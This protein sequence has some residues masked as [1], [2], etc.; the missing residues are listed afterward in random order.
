[1]SFVNPLF[2]IGALAVAAPILLHLIKREHARKIEFPSLMFLRR[3]SRKS[4]RYQKL[5]HLLILLLR[6]LAFLL[7]VFAFMRPYREK[8]GAASVVGKINSAHV[9]LIDNSLSMGYQ[10]RWSRAKAAAAAIVRKADPDDRFA[11]LEFSDR[12]SALT[13]LTNDP[14]DAQGQI[15]NMKLSDGSTRYGQALRAAEKFALDAG[16]GKRV[17]HLISDFQKNGFLTDDQDFRLSAGIELRHVDMGA[18]SYSNLA[19]RDVHVSE[20]DQGAGNTITIKA[21]VADFGDQDRKNVRV[22]LLVDGR[23][24]TEKRVDIVKGGSQGIEF[25]L[26]ALLSGTHSAIIEVDDPYLAGDNRFY[27]T[28]ETRG[29]T[30]VLVVESGE[31]GRSSSFFLSKALNVDTLSPYK[32]TAVT[33]QSFV[34]SGGL[35]IWNN[36]AGGGA[37]QKKLQDFVKT[38]GGLALVLGDSVQAAEFNHSFGSWLPVR[39]EEPGASAGFSGRR[40]AENYVM[41]TDVRMD[42]PIFQPFSRPHSGSFSSARFF[43]HARIS[44]GSGAEILSRFDNGDPALVS[45]REEKGRV[46][47]FTSSADDSSNDLPLKAVYAPFWQQMLHYLENF[48]ERRHW[49]DVGETMSPRKLLVDT[50]LRQPKANVD[51]NGPVVVLTPDKQ[52]IPVPPGSDDVAVDK[53]GFYETRT[54][55]V[56]ASV[57]VNAASRESDLSH[58]NAEE[59]TAGWMS[60]KSA[61]FRQDERPSPGDQDRRQRIWALLL[62]AAVL[63]L[64]SELFLANREPQSKSEA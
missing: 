12:C 30:P 59:M 53:A 35:V 32:V 14:A 27:M 1:M 45:V 60:S 55:N 7:I 54:M 64:T 57:A 4:I 19:V 63:F 3:I 16:T 44:T 39:M 5:R 38:G 17:I 42:H 58:G 52:R 47:I 15:K 48:Q 37:A 24:I 51:L 23:G 20:S 40:S 18:D 61:V 25:Q 9:I 13:Q 22:S 8:T 26:P 34:L 56:N 36:L 46:L 31:S 33:P 62:I 6:I 43:G 2:M 50:A 11:V 41:M 49:L 10:D 29:K 28:I 21:S